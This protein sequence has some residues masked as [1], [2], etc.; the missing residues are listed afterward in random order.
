MPAGS[1]GQ[2]FQRADRQAKGL[3]GA[4]IGWYTAVPDLSLSRYMSVSFVVV[5]FSSNSKSLSSCIQISTLAQSMKIDL[6]CL[7]RV[8]S[9]VHENT[10]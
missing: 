1:P 6:D 3:G 2:P 4:Q 9:H 8:S 7:Q 10:I 5:Y